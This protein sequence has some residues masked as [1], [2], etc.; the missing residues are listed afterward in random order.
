MIV[1]KD[2]FLLVL[3]SSIPESCSW[4]LQANNGEVHKIR[5]SFLQSI[6]FLGQ[7]NEQAKPTTIGWAAKSFL[8]LAR[9]SKRESQY[10]EFVGKRE[11]P[12]GGVEDEKIRALTSEKPSHLAALEENLQTLPSHKNLLRRSPKDLSQWRR[13]G[14]TN[15]PFLW[16]PHS[17][18]L[19]VHKSLPLWYLKNNSTASFLPQSF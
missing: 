7:E 4:L 9:G 14:S 15:M 16:C 5:G 1:S 19:E 11:V 17:L 10:S 2:T 13:Y 12:R 3:N 6:N 18:F 8:H